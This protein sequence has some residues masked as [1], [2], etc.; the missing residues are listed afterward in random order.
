MVFYVQ[1]CSGA[2]IFLCDHRHVDHSY[3]FIIGEWSN[4]YTNL[5]KRGLAIYLYSYQ[6][7]FSIFIARSENKKY[8]Q[9]PFLVLQLVTN[10]GQQLEGPINTQKD[11]NMNIGKGRSWIFGKGEN[12]HGE[13]TMIVQR[14][15]TSFLLK[16]TLRPYFSL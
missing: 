5:R 3:N 2:H 14:L 16:N 13:L 11:L 6:N 4:R 12:G 9:V 15:S 10:G 8:F 1:A 7:S